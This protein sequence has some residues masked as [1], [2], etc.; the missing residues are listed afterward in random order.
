MKKITLLLFAAIAPFAHGANWFVHKQSTGTNAGTSWTNAFQDM[1][2]I[3]FSS[4]ACGD[5]IWLG[6]GTYSDTLA[7]VKNCSAGAT[8]NIKR[9]LST[10][11]VPVAAPGWSSSFDSQVILLNWSGF[12]GIRLNGINNVIIDGRQGNPM[13]S[14]PVPMG[15]SLQ[16]TTTQCDGINDGAGN[17][18][19]TIQYVEVYGPPCVETATCVGNGASGVNLPFGGSGFNYNHDY[20]HRWGEALRS[21][22]WNGVTIERN[23]IADTHNDHIQHEDIWYENGGST[24]FVNVTWRYNFIWMSPNDGMFFDNGGQNGLFDYGNVYFHSGGQLM[25]FKSVGTKATNIFVYNNVFENDTTFGDFQPAW[26]DWTNVNT[27]S[28][29]FKNNIMQQT[30]NVSTPPSPDYNGYDANGVGTDSGAHTFTY[31]P[32][33]G[34]Q[35]VNYSPGSPL[36]A[37]FHLSTTGQTTFKTG[38]TLAS[39]YNVDMDG[40]TRGS[41]GFWTIGA[42]QTATAATTWYVDPAIGGPRNS[43]TFTTAGC[44][45]KGTSTYNSGGAANQS[46]PF[47][48]FRYL[49][50]DPSNTNAAAWVIA[51]GD[52]VNVNCTSSAP[53]RASGS[54]NSS[55]GNFCFGIGT[56]CVPP[57]LPS[58]TVG[59]PT[60]IQGV[61]CTSGCATTVQAYNTTSA[62]YSTQQPN[63][64]SIAYLWGSAGAFYVLS[65]Q[66]AQN[67]TIRGLDIT[68]HSNCGASGG[69]TCTG[70]DWTSYGIYSGNST[71][72]T[73]G[74]IALQDLRIH[75]MQSRGILGNIGGTWTVTRVL[76]QANSQ[77]NWDF[78]PGG[79]Q[80]SNGSVN[81]TWLGIVLGGCAEEFPIVDTIPVGSLSCTS[82]STGGYGDGVGT[83]VTGPINWNANHIYAYYNTQDGVDL[84]HLNGST[85][86]FTN[87]FFYGNNGGNIKVGPN[88]SVSVFNNIIVSGCNRMSQSITG[89]GSGFNT[90]LSDYCRAG[91]ANGIN[92]NTNAT[93]VFNST[94]TD[95]ARDISCTGTACTSTAGTVGISVG[96]TLIPDT[97]DYTVWAR[98]VATK[99]DNS[100]WTMSSAYPSNFTNTYMVHV[101]TTPASTSVIKVYHNTVANYS[102]TFDNQCQTGFPQNQV[103]FNLCAGYT[104]DYRDNVFAAYGDTVSPGFGPGHVWPE[105]GP[106]TED[107]NTCYNYVTATLNCTGAHDLTVSPLFTSQPAT[108][109]SA[110]SA[111][112]NFNMNLSGSSP[113]KAA[114]IAI[115]GQTTDYIGTAWASTP[116]MGAIQAAISATVA[117]PTASPAA[118]TYT[119][120]Q[121]VTLSTSTAGATICYTT[122]G[123]TPAATTPGTCD[124]G[125]STYST[126][127]AVAGNQTIKAI[128]TLVGDTNSS[129]ASLAYIITPSTYTLSPSGNDSNPGT[130]ALPWLSPNHALN[131]GDTI[132]A[133]ASTSYNS[134][135]FQSAKW[136]TVTGSTGFANLKCATPFACRIAVTTGN[137]DGMQ[138]TTSHWNISGWEVINISSSTSNGNCIEV[139]PASSS[140]SIYDIIIQNNTMN[141]CDGGGI[142]VRDTSPAGVDYVSILGNIVYQAGATNTFCTAGISVAAPVKL[143]STAGTHIYVAGNFVSGSTNPSGCFD[144][145]GIILESMQVHSYD[146]QMVAY[147]N[148]SIAN[149]GFGIFAELNTAAP[150]YL[151]QN[152]TW[153]NTFGTFLSGATRGGD[154][155]F[156][157]TTSSHALNNISQANTVGIGGNGSNPSPAFYVESVDGSSSVT[158]NNLYSASGNFTQAVSSTG[159]S[160]GTNSTTNPSF[161]SPA[162]PSAPSCSGQPTTT[163]CMATTIANFATT[164]S[165]GYK[166][167]IGGSVFDALFPQWLCPAGTVVPGIITM[168]CSANAPTVTIT[169]HI[170][171]QGVII[172]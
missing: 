12:A 159:F 13:G 79:S 89:T 114:G 25:T 60:T 123:S 172:Q 103:N 55:S 130:P 162:A 40:N 17:S 147:N 98:T 141:T 9:V 136:G 169:G 66:D 126:A 76:L 118:G 59:Q 37:D 52:I 43:S 170:T 10:D 64:A 81:S 58:G 5:T 110:E 171:M 38:T 15:I 151:A 75:G 158:S 164:V 68:D 35:F 146:Q 67:I 54:A 50:D 93:L 121:S 62:L 148:L 107:Y 21:A 125:S 16:C 128:G 80:A 127:I 28:G 109:I 47:S 160:F 95:Y 3:N 86:S 29:A 19:Y 32:S 69:P 99:T 72:P 41:T 2:S 57:A 31:S 156:Y 83:P 153:H 61:N 14:S 133:I 65:V 149:G 166:T 87:G 106:S 23:W 27:S 90:N 161:P 152:T 154:M 78:D 53:C 119:S 84:G 117:T 7:A 82:Q 8:L 48:D 1:G 134:T 102:D 131:V 30:Y 91:T 132:S 155:I 22:N 143:D 71:T 122:N 120:A 112:D 46:C 36:L 111:L 168:G 56:T 20:I 97:S 49:W 34:T 85:I 140:T 100:H 94:S 73:N 163:A 108:P 139:F 18:N 96:Q 70:T 129:V 165:L 74:N 135:N 42:Y 45:G 77:A 137:N 26:I 124:A 92:V 157:S 142:A 6:G 113:A 105:M 104:A 115:S 145:E 33:L 4:V 88:P 39:P 101:P 138:V 167:P 11:A 44:T 63:P 116:S 24:A 144:G 150:I 51:G